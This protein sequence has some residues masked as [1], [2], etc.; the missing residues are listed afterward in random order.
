M[1]VTR[2]LLGH[3]ETISNPAAK[4]AVNTTPITASGRRREVSCTAP[5][6]PTASRAARPAPAMNG[7]PISPATATPGTTA[8]LSASPSRDQP[9]RVTNGD[10][11]AHSAPTTPPTRTAFCM[12]S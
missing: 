8:W 4:N 1:L 6:A 2:R 10:S 9:R 11:R 5:M 12:N 3:T 7:A